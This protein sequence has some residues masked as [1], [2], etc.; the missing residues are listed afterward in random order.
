MVGMEMRGEQPRR[1]LPGK[2][3]VEQ[4]VPGFAGERGVHAGVDQ[5]DSLA[6]IESP[7]VDVPERARHGHA[8]PADAGRDLVKR[9]E[10]GPERP[11]RIDEAAMAGRPRERRV[12]R[13]RGHARG[14]PLSA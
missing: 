12:G 6:V 10:L 9:A 8:R 3:A 11:K 1:A 5:G 4:P 7:D 14:A 2:R 13:G